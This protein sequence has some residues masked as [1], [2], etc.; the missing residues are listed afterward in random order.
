MRFLI[1]KKQYPGKK[2]EMHLDY[3][4]DVISMMTEIRKSQGLFYPEEQEK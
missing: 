2:N 3:T 4:V 1:W